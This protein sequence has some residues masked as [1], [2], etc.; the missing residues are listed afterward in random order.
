MARLA[1]LALALCGTALA[2]S[3][4]RAGC[5]RV[6]KID[7]ELPTLDLR[8][9]APGAAGG[10]A[11]VLFAGPLPLGASANVCVEGDAVVY[12]EWDPAL[13]AFGP[14]VTAV[15]QDGGDVEL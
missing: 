2:P 9:C 7:A 14:F 12:E 11:S 13:G 1:A 6:V 5:C 4:A 10:C 15:C 3:L 8:V